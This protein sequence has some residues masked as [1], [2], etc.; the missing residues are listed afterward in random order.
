MFTKSFMT[1]YKDRISAENNL[2]KLQRE[3]NYTKVMLTVDKR[4]DAGYQFSTYSDIESL[5]YYPNQKEALFFPFSVWEVCSIKEVAFNREVGYE[6]KLQFL[7]RFKKFTETDKTIIETE[8]ALPE[9]EFK[10]QICEFGLINKET[11]DKITTKEL[12]EQYKKYDEVI[13][14]KEEEII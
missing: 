4:D 8:I 11:A 1:F 7:K 5:S 3:K 13:K 12:Y 6:I 2:A 14:N 9:S 10:N